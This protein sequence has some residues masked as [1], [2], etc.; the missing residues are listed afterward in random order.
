MNKMEQ[1]KQQLREEIVVAVKAAGLATDETI[2]EVILETP[3]E[4]AHGD[5]A[6]NMAMQLARV[7]KKAPRL[8]AEEL[9]AKLD[10]KRAAIEKIEIAGPGFINFFLDNS[11]LREMIPTVLR[12]E[13]A[14]GE[15]NVGKGKKVQVEFVSANPTG[16]LHL[17]HARGA[18]VGDALCNI[19]AKAGYDVSREYY[20]NDAGNQIN[21]LA[22]SLEARYFQALG[23]EKDMPEDGYHGEDIIQFGKD[24][25]ETHGD[26]FVH[27]SSEERLAFF[28]EYGLKR[29]LEKIK[30]DLEEFRVPFD[31]W[32]SETSLYTTGKVEKTL[33]VLKEKGK[34]YE[35][36][37]AL[38]FR[39]TEYG[40]D[41]DRV[42]VKNDGS[43]TYLTPDISYHEDK[44]LRGFEKL[45]N[46]WG[47]DH[48][49]YIPRMKAAIQALGYEKDQ[50]DVQIIQMVS[51]FQNGEKVKMS[52]RTGKAVTLRDLM[53]EVG[54]DAT[55]YFFAMRSAD[56]HLDFDMDLA[57]SKSNENPVYYVQY[58][59]ARVCSMLRKGKELGL[60]FDE[61][62]DLSPIASEKEYDLLKKIG[63]FPEVVAE[64]AQKQMPHRITNYVH[65]LASTLHSFYNAEQVINPENDEQ[66]KARLALMKATQ[67]TLKNALSLVGVEAP[68]RM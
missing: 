10:R 44:F 58:A 49:G 15:T 61:S 66:S 55:R 56:S 32:Y 60:S 22:L 12:A 35:Q 37:G 64:A 14:Y 24:L 67:V 57:V 30:S 50:L 62:T 23:M 3:K 41:K 25:A 2:P 8:I 26:K 59:H 33:N 48:H 28:R 13:S 43:Y 47:A 45:I 16:N 31:N 4:K 27:E 39:S 7:A 46:I 6:T 38:W 40:D 19:L 11:Y 53:E 63:E 68:E 34:T 1:M 20:I 5:F 17:G 42:L 54:I 51:L 9:T 21:N 18:A 36:D 52:K 65:E 29:E